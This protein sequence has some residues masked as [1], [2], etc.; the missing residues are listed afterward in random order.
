VLQKEHRQAAHTDTADA[1][2]MKPFARKSVKSVR[3]HFP[4]SPAFYRRMMYPYICPEHISSLK[5]TDLYFTAENAETTEKISKKPLRALRSL[6]LNRED[7]N[8]QKRAMKEKI[9]R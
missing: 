2:E 4:S 3:N 8:A 7:F 6:R 1:Y 9:R 5:I